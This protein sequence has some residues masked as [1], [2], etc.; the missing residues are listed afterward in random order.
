[1]PIIVPDPPVT[2]TSTPTALSDLIWDYLPEYITDAD[3][4]TLRSLVDAVAAPVAAQVSLLTDP[5]YSADEYTTPFTRVPWLAALAGVDVS[6]IPDDRKRAVIADPDYRY[7]GSAAAIRKRVG[8]TLTGPKSVEIT[9]PVGGDPDQI[10]VTTFASQTP[11]AAVT[12]A[13]IR[14]EIPAWMQATIVTNAAGQSYS[15]LAA[16]YATYAVMAATSKTY[17]TLSQEV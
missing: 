14:A 10:A 7:R 4:G 2:A 6:T 15:N 12:E 5:A 8:E 11:D 3:D 9:C 17:G 13:A 1:M 16:D